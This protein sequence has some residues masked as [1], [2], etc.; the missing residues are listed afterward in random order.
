M[1][2]KDFSLKTK[3]ENEIVEAIR[4]AEKSTSGE[5]RVHLEK[6][7]GSQ[8]IACTLL[9]L[10]SFLCPFVKSGALSFHK[11]GSEIKPNPPKKS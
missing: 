6:S 5:I 8:D 11:P 3:D 9:R 10:P 7:S 2:R 4:T 1:S